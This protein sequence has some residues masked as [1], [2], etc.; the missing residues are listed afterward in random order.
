MLY[1]YTFCVNIG[2]H[3]RQELVNSFK[4][5]IKSLNKKI[6]EYQIICYTNFKLR[7]ILYKDVIFR[8]YYSRHK[9][10][11]NNWHNLSFNKIHVYKDLRD[12]FNIDYIWIDLDTLIVS[13]ISYINNYSNIFLEIGGNCVSPNRIFEN[14]KIIIP[15]NRYIQ[16]N[17]WKLDID[18]YKDLMK[19][20]SIIKQKKLQLRCDGQDLFTYYIYVYKDE[21]KIKTNILGNNVLPETINGLGMFADN[22]RT[23]GKIE[24]INN[25]Y[26]KDNKLKSKYYPDKDIHIVSFV[27]RRVKNNYNHQIFKKLFSDYVN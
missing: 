15:R 12:E 14:S 16:G 18:L 17:V 22:T 20:Y 4:Y 8:D 5:L 11:S 27:F 23:Q 7:S 21:N 9:D 6:K 2:R 1:F 19:V 10:F 24:E 26:L 3:S 25:L 13:D